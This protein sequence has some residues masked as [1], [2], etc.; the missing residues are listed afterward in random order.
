MRRI[1]LIL[2]ALTALAGAVEARAARVVYTV[3]PEADVSLPFWC[4]WSYDWEE[5]CYRDFSDRLSVGG[6]EDKVWRSALRFP[7]GGVPP[8]S[9][10]DSATLSLWF[11]GVCLAPRKTEQPCPL[12]RYTLD[13]HPILGPDWFREREVDTGPPAD[14]ATLST[15]A[16]RRVSWDVTGLVADWVQNDVPNNGLLLKLAE[17]EER[18]LAS[19]PK[20]PSS[21]F[22]DPGLRPLLEV[23]Y[24]AP[25]PVAPAAAYE[26]RGTMMRSC[27]SPPTAASASRRSSSSSTSSSSSRSRS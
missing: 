8:G 15:A 21:E 22:A 12:P 11:D 24:L 23:T 14:Q 19:G 7:L 26:C 17:G 27:R 13:V 9:V 2:V 1:A 4:D 3:A 18:F 5:R 10:V 25:G 6:D 16:P 20:F